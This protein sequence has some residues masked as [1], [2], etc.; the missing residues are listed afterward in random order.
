MVN[1]YT[2]RC[3]IYSR[4]LKINRSVLEFDQ[5]PLKETCSHTNKKPFNFLKFVSSGRKCVYF[6]RCSPLFLATTVCFGFSLRP[7]FA[8]D[9]GNYVQLLSKV[10]GF[11]IYLDIFL[12]YLHINGLARPECC[13]RHKRPEALAPVALQCECGGKRFEYKSDGQSIT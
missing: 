11:C 12:P 1:T 7:K 13:R 10:N 4:P 3:V 5:C 2:S 9:A 8:T 6:S